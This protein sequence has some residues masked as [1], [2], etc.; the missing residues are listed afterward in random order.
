MVFMKKYCVYILRSELYSEHYYTG[1]TENLEER[2]KYHNNGQVPHT[3][4]YRPW[5]MKTA[6][7]FS[8]RNQAVQFE[9]YLK[10]PSGRAFSKK[11]L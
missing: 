8:D 10:S 4:K 6:M 3:A 5:I 7:I 1:F 9:K 2:L 11:R